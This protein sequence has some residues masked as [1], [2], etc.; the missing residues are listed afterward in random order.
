MYQ[1]S[2]RYTSI[3]H[4]VIHRYK[5][6][7]ILISHCLNEQ[8]HNKTMELQIPTMLPECKHL[9][10]KVFDLRLFSGQDRRPCFVDFRNRVRTMPYHFYYLYSSPQVTE[11]KRIEYYMIKI[12]AKNPLRCSSIWKWSQIMRAQFVTLIQRS[13]CESSDTAKLCFITKPNV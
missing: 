12:K 1:P 13:I 11:Q 3:E 4:K 7:G 8:H 10:R 2:L 6:D 9:F 5:M